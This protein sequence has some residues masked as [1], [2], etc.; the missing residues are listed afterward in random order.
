[1]SDTHYCTKCFLRDLLKKH[2]CCEYRSLDGSGNNKKHSDYGKSNQCVLRVVKQEY[3]DGHGKPTG[4][5]RPSARIVSNQVLHQDEPVFNSKHASNIFWLWGQ[6][7]D[8]DITL[9]EPH[10]EQFNIPVPKGDQYFDPYCE[11]E[12]Y[13]NLN[14][15]EYVHGTGVKGKP[16]K[17]INKLTPFIDG[18]N[19]YSTTDERNKYIR[20]YKDGLL[21]TST[22]DLLP[23]NDGAQENAGNLFGKLFVGGDIRSNEHV[24]LTAIHT[25]FVR[26]HNYWARKIKKLKP[27]MCDEKI[28]QKAKI[29]VE[30]EI[31]S[32]TFNEFLP[33]LLGKCNIEKYNAYNCNIN[34]Q[35]S[36][37][38]SAACYRLHTL[39][40]SKILHDSHLKDLYFKPYL[41]CNKYSLDHIFHNYINRTCEEMDGKVTGDLRNFLFGDPG[42]GG[43]DLAALNIQRGRDHGLPDYNSIRCQLGLKKKRKFSEISDDKEHNNKMQKTYNCI[44]DVDIYVGGSHES[45]SSN[46]SML[47]E[48]FHK[49]IKE[50]FEKIRN[51]DR[52]WYENRLNCSQI[53]Y[54]NSTTLSDI[55][56][57]NTCLKEIQY[58]VFIN[59]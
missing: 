49:V 34:P 37:L 21:K 55:L 32:I 18:S 13:I 27:T 3:E 46:C 58:N 19:V 20:K 54:I 43:H 33:L 29:I 7:I 41:L 6:F 52:L 44:D 9:T 28:Y 38:F 56:K 57:R 8:H 22:G 51:G 30:A 16:R 15:T 45:K 5:K 53:K 4:Y 23:V 47:G 2:S 25:L 17:Y 42:K 39:I 24:G 36:N 26:E 10:D 14:R 50:Q 35:V 12:K 31:Q 48:L 59:K 40:P 11:G 1:M